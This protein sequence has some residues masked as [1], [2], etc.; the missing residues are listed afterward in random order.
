MFCDEPII[1]VFCMYSSDTDGVQGMDLH[2]THCLELH[3]VGGRWLVFETDS[4]YI[5]AGADGVRISDKASLPSEGVWFDYIDD[6]VE[7]DE[8]FTPPISYEKV[9]F[10]GERLVDVSAAECDES[11][12]Y[13]AGYVLSF[14]HF[15]MNM[16]IYERN[17]W[18]YFEYTI[19]SETDS[20]PVAACDH[21]LT[22]RCTCGGE[23]EVMLDFVEDFIVR[24]KR[25]HASTW[26]HMSASDALDDWNN[27]HTP[28]EHHTGF[29]R[30]CRDLSSKDIEYIALSDNGFR[31]YDDDLFESRSVVISFAEDRHYLLSSQYSCANLIELSAE[32][33]TGYN[34]DLY[35]RVIY[36]SPNGSI[37]F[38][39][40]DEPPRRNYLRLALDDTQIVLTAGTDCAIMVGIS[41]PDSELYNKSRRRTLLTDSSG[42]QA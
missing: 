11:A 17:G 5:Y 1:G 38:V 8:G 6:P 29:E 21:L 15:S 12:D 33:L 9:I 37:S 2:I 39:G 14:D 35:S 34:R 27:A 16:Y 19:N 13:S 32:N 30:L 42:Q 26:A 25:C 23:G 10:S 24:C 20:N 4:H 7:D 3:V 41:C 22:R 28:V 18:R 36:P 31:A 40:F